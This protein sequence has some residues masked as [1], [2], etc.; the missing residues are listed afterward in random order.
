MYI[1]IY[2]H[3]Y[4]MEERYIVAELPR[5]RDRLREYHVFIYVYTYMRIKWKK[6]T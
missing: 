2:I 3:A 5:D 6:D 4:K 1:C